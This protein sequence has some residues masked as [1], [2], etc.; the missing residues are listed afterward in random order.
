L[1]DNEKE[2]GKIL[3]NKVVYVVVNKK[4]TITGIRFGHV[5]EKNRI[6]PKK[7]CIQ[8]RTETTPP[9]SEVLTKPSRIPSSVENTAVT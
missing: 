3:A 4:P 6:P 8:W 7:Y 9:N 2:N 1:Y 5:M